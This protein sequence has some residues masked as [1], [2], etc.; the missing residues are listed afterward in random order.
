[1]TIDQLAKPSGTATP[2]DSIPKYSATSVSASGGNAILR[3]N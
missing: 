2:G 3:H 1:M